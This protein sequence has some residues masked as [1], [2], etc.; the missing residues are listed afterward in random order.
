MKGAGRFVFWIASPNGNHLTRT[1]A[2]CRIGPGGVRGTMFGRTMP[3]GKFISRA[4]RQVLVWDPGV[5]LYLVDPVTGKATR[6]RGE[7][8]GSLQVIW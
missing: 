5:A 2:G 3:A 7:G 4:G 8:T 6:V 1:P